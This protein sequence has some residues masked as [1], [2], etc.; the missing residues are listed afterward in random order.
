MFSCC[1]NSKI[2][3]AESISILG[4][5]SVDRNASMVLLVFRVKD[6]IE[7]PYCFN[8]ICSN[9]TI[10]VVMSAETSLFSKITSFLGKL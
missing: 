2:T 5:F 10:V 3:K 7:D 8:Y 1:K 4:P 9:T 6:S